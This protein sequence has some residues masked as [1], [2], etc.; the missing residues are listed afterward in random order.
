LGGCLGHPRRDRGLQGG[1]LDEERW[2]RL[3]G[4]LGDG[5]DVQSLHIELYPRVEGW[6][7]K[8]SSVGHSWDRDV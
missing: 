1:Q 2:Q 7:W 6:S 3:D 8:Y 5:G 4:Q